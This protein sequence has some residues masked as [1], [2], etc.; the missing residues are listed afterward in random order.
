[1]PSDGAMVDIGG[2]MVDGGDDEIAESRDVL[3]R[4]KLANSTN[5][6][7]GKSELTRPLLFSTHI[8]FFFWS[9]QRSPATT[10]VTVDGGTWRRPGPNLSGKDGWEGI[11]R[12]SGEM[13]SPGRTSV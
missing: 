13:V 3:R 10:E 8:V 2:R 12:I 6:V 1:M 5:T 9:T 11:G 7:I 4:R